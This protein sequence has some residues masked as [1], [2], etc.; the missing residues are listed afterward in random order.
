MIWKTRY[1]GLLLLWYLFNIQELVL[2]VYTIGIK[3]SIYITRFKKLFI[4]ISI[5][6]TF[7]Y[8]Q[9]VAWSLTNQVEQIEFKKSEFKGYY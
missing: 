2:R 9:I 1:K 8:M 3:L 7:I 6:F 5:N 4:I